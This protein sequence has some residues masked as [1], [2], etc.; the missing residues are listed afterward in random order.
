MVD[1][2]ISCLAE[3][4]FESERLGQLLTFF[5]TESMPEDV[6]WEKAAFELNRR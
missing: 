2:Q 3:A 6:L 4:N 5:H 1:Q